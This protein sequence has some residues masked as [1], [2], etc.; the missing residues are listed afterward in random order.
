M[1]RVNDTSKR[2]MDII[3]SAD[4]PAFTILPAVHIRA[5]T[6]AM[7]AYFFMVYFSQMVYNAGRWWDDHLPE[8]LI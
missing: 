1:L 7:I 6:C 5:T 4:T 3:P 2:A 8:A